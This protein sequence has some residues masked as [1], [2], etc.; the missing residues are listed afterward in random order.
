[1]LKEQFLFH[2]PGQKGK[3]P[4]DT[5]NAGVMEEVF[6]RRYTINVQLIGVVAQKGTL[7]FNIQHD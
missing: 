4:L 6:Y 5:D 2:Q 1:M 3:A 7:W